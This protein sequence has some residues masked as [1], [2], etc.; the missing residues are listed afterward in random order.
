MKQESNRSFCDRHVADPCRAFG[1][2][3]SRLVKEQRARF[4]ILR[5]SF[6]SEFWAKKE[7][8]SSSS[9]SSS[10]SSYVRRIVP[11]NYRKISS[12]KILVHLMRI[13]SFFEIMMSQD[14]AGSFTELTQPGQTNSVNE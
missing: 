11:Y 5:R 1:R 8:R 3:C 4:Y 10:S 2:R 6:S 13:F 7:C 14:H 12:L 9:S